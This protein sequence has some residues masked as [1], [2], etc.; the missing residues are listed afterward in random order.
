MKSKIKTLGTIALLGLSANNAMAT[1]VEGNVFCDA[2]NSGV[3]EY[4]MDVPLANAEVVA[5][6]LPDGVDSLCT[7]GNDTFIQTTNA[8]GEYLIHLIKSTNLD[9]QVI[10]ERSSLPG[11]A[12]I[13]KPST[14]PAQFSFPMSS[15]DLYSNPDYVHPYVAKMD[16]L[17]ESSACQAPIPKIELCTQV[18]LNDDM[19]SDFSD[20]D[21]ITGDSCDDLPQGVPVGLAGEVNGSYKLKV[22]NIGTETLVDVRINAPDFGIVNEAI[23]ADCGSSLGAGE[24][25]TIEISD[26]DSLLKTNVCTVP[27][28]VTNMASVK[29][30]GAVSGILVSDDDPAVV[31]CVAEP[32]IS[33]LK[34]VSLDGIN[35]FDANS[36]IAGPSGTLGDDA[37][38]RLTITND[39]TESIVNPVINDAAL[40][41]IDVPLGVAVMLPG[42]IVVL[43]SASFNFEALHAVD[44]CDS[45]G[46][47][48]NS[49][50][51]DGAG[52]FS[53]A[54]V[55][56]EDVAYI[57]CEKP[58]IEILKQVSLDGI[59]FFEADLATD[60][61]VPV[62]AIGSTDASYRLIIKNIGS[63][64]LTDV[65][66]TD[67]KLGIE[68]FVLDLEAGESS[69][70]NLTD[71]GF[72]S[73][74]Q[75]DVCNGTTGNQLN[76]ATVTA[77]G[78]D[79][80]Q[81]VSDDNPANLRCISGPAIEIKK[82]VRIDTSAQYVD[83]DTASNSPSG[84][85]GDDVDYRVLVRNVG[86]EDLNGVSISDSQ[87]GILD[88]VIGYLAV[89]AEVVIDNSVPGFE[90]LYAVGHCNSTGNKL[91]VASVTAVG[92]ITNT[93][94]NDDDPAYVS[95]NAP[96]N[97]DVTVNQTCAVKPQSGD[98]KLCTAAIS[99]TTLRYIGPDLSG[100]N[101]E[102]VGK[103][104]G[105]V[106]YSGVDLVSGVTIL[107]QPSQNG[108]TVD[109]GDH[110]NIGSKLQIF[111]NGVEE[112]VHTSCSAVYVAGQPAPLDG[113]T[114][115]PANS[116]KGDPSPNWF[117]VDFRQKDDLFVAESTEP[118]EGM[119]TCELP[120]GGGEVVYG[121]KVLN[122]GT[123]TLELTSVLDSK[124]G[125]VLMS[126]PTTLSAG[127]TLNL[128][129]EPVF[130]SENTVS[131]VNV[132]ANVL[133][134]T[135]VTCSAIDST[136]VNVVTVTQPEASC[137][138]GKPVK[139][140]ITYVGG[141]CSDSN[142]QQGSD[143][144]RCEGDSS[145]LSPVTLTLTDKSGNIYVSQ[146]VNQGDTVIVD[147]NG[148]RLSSETIAVIT[149]GDQTV[150]SI[151]F[152][153]SCSVPLA[154]GDQHGGIVISSFTP[155]DGS[156]KGGKGG[157]DK[158][159]STKESKQKKDK[160]KKD[161]KK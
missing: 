161:K 66:V 67:A 152:H 105:S 96:V 50:R 129:S 7:A 157:K 90:N 119:D 26:F 45:I 70:I 37:F 112:I 12:A 47:H 39:G 30:N 160:K 124:L 103:A 35:Y 62:G 21:T 40:G 154:V 80:Q 41:L 126:S 27:G 9:Y 84:M 3:I 13:L 146:L 143:K 111:I 159:V 32:H 95:C 93:S 33:L 55:S 91:N 10:L 127:S 150:Q 63:E 76:V 116:E 151:N 131:T 2:N 85:L 52:E 108:Y 145:G 46:S 92:S 24:S 100:A 122:S 142:H 42:D 71:T 57:R 15:N 137:A 69:V 77:I 60:A 22:T 134:D 64:M 139:L 101:V 5:K 54:A 74:Y 72:E 149:Q 140:G 73:L 56:G 89:G 109:A 81:L 97:C 38:Y 31:N 75:T 148:T 158:K 118:G 110:Q 34:E 29:G 107:T 25:C 88:L 128:T 48:L 132:N 8:Q 120:N 51:V 147:G 36:N 28:M 16:W 138:D 14:L 135:G 68:E 123:T 65:K 125:E 49:A 153:T 19:I 136:P 87:L 20:A 83:A 130:I 106:I 53:A 11:D 114:P 44:R 61:D 113:N 115:N 43:D 156:S 6:C 104:S 4:D 141:S 23:P 102:F 98:D 82:Q 58:Q 79:T 78:V 99:A 94:V 1:W 18:T 121:Y 133:G 155:D 59:N 144:S 17:I 86:G 117:V